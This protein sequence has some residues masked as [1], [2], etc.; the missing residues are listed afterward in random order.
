MC[1]S[2]QHIYVFIGFDLLSPYRLEL[3][4]ILFNKYLLVEAR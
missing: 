3:T 1:I 2:N 4:V